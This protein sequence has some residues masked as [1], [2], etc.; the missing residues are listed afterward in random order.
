[1]PHQ[2]VRCGAIYE[3]ASPTLL[4]GCDCGS[5]F[6]FYFKEKPQEE[7]LE[8]LTQQQRQEIEEDVEELIGPTIEDETPV[9]LD[10]ESVRIKQPGKFELDLVNMFKRKPLIY[11]L[12]EGKYIID[13]ASTFQLGKKKKE[14]K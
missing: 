7:Q 11:K 9:I 5:R 6:F 13:I 1:M 8:Q 12:E 14:K 10:M 3:D 4:S 2:C